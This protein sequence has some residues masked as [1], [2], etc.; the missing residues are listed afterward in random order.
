MNK[1]NEMSETTNKRLVDYVEG[2]NQLGTPTMV[3]LPAGNYYFKVLEDQFK[4][5]ITR[6]GLYQELDP[7]FFAEEDGEFNIFDTDNSVMYLPSVTKVLF[8]EKKYPD[9]KSNQLFAPIALVFNEETVDILGQILELLPA[10]AG[11]INS[12]AKKGE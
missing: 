12:T 9:L 6:S 8:A 11:G 2:G 4:L 10:P 1:E 7:E 5:T 3:M